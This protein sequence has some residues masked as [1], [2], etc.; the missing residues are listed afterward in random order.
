M[1]TSDPPSPR[2]AQNAKGPASRLMLTNSTKPSLAELLA[3]LDD[4]QLGGG[5][6]EKKEE[7][8]N[9]HTDRVAWNRHFEREISRKS[10]SFSYTL[11]L[12]EKSKSPQALLGLLGRGVKEINQDIALMIREMME[13][14]GR[15]IANAV[16]DLTYGTLEADWAAFDAK[17]KAEILLEGL[18]RGACYA[19]RDNSRISCPEMTIAGLAGDGEYSFLNLLKTL[20]AHDPTGNGCVKELFIFSHPIVEH[21]LLYTDQASEMIKAYLYHVGMLRNYYIVSTL[22]GTLEAYPAKAVDTCRH[23]GKEGKRAFD[24][25]FKA[26]GLHVDSSQCKEESAIAVYAC[27]GCRR[28]KTREELKNCG[29]CRLVR[30]C[31]KECAK[32]DWKEH[33]KFCGREG[34]DPARLMP[35]PQL[36][37]Q[38]IGCPAPVD[39]YIRTPALWRQIGY[40]SKPDSQFQDY[41]FNIEPDRT[42]SIRI[43]APPGAQIIFLVARRRAMASGCPAS[44]EMMLAIIK[45]MWS[46]GM[47]PLTPQQIMTQFETEYRLKIV[48]GVG[49]VGAGTFAPPTKKEKREE[50]EYRR[51]RLLTARFSEEEPADTDW[52]SP[53]TREQ[54]EAGEALQAQPLHAGTICP[55]CLHH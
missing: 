53:P 2:T 13:L 39:G 50:E 22:Q 44:V 55:C 5:K 27:Y 18:Y 31:S 20:V 15:V 26:A 43:L 37:A 48:E 10:A 49:V 6:K 19:P 51:Q 36:P 7:R 16:E 28:A 42:R 41:H 8:P 30:Y 29:G 33:K 52:V 45:Y 3:R 21:E 34:F 35:A 1:P 25:G 47:V 40:L 54:F 4:L 32:K 12:L 24:A 46:H 11:P 17:Q 38:F 9:K 14:E 23:G